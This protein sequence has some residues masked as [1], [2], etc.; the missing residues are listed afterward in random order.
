MNNKH[1]LFEAKCPIG[2][3]DFLHYNGKVPYLLGDMP[4]FAKAADDKRSWRLE[5]KAQ[6]MEKVGVGRLCYELTF[7]GLALVPSHGE[8]FVCRI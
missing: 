8:E 3:V 4:S 5:I 7:R 1:N 6:R 2:F